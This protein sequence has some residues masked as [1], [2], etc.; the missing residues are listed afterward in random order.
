[1]A[2]YSEFKYGAA[3]YGE[4]T[5]NSNL[6]WTFIVKWTGYYTGEND[7]ER[8]VDLTI[9][10][11][12]DFLVRPDGNGWERYKPGTAVGIFDNSDGRYDPYNT[13]SPLYPYVTPGKSVIIRVKNNSNGLNYNVM[14]G[15]ISDIQPINRGKQRFVAIKVMDGLQLLADNKVQIG[16]NQNVNVA[17]RINRV[18]DACSFPKTEW[19]YYSDNNGETL[20]YFWAWNKNALETIHDLEDH[21]GGVFLHN[22]FGE[23]YFYSGSSTH[24]GTV[25]V[26]EDELLSDISIPQPW[27]VVRNKINVV[28][29]PK[30]LDAVNTT[31]WQLDDVPAI[32]NGQTLTFDALFRYNYYQ[33]CGS[34]VQFNLTVNTLANGTGTNLSSGCVLGYGDIGDGVTITVTNNSGSSGYITLL[35]AVGNV[36]YN[37]YESVQTSSDSTSQSVY[38]TRQFE[39]DGKWMQS[40][41][42]GKS[43]ADWVLSQLKDP[44]KFPVV[45]IENRPALQFG[46]DL[47]RDR[48]TLNAPTFGISGEYFRIGKIE[49]RWLR[50]NGQAVRTLWKLEPYLAA[51]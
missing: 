9:T 17:S 4:T 38:G 16:L 6:L 12:R 48:I 7:G 8:L 3:K 10:R 29:S 19:P 35:R 27:E 44:K 32:A 41:A 47:Y 24:T 13:S 20:P 46:R 42:Y 2:R 49:H 28:T 25:T 50:E 5:P 51:F 39:V 26:D 40:T 15:R 21:D 36:I 11:G 34:S 31:I 30:R 14:W 18:L 43:Y 37:P 45:Q 1:M 22:R 23:M 33:P